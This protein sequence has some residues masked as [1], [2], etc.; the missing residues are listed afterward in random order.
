VTN[1]TLL[2]GAHGFRRRLRAVLTFLA[3]VALR[4]ACRIAVDGA[5]NVP[6]RG[7][8]I[9]VGN[10]VNPVEAPLIAGSLPRSDLWVVVSDHLRQRRA[11]RRVLDLMYDILWLNR[12]NGRAELLAR[13]PP[14]LAAGRVVA[15]MPEGRYSWNGRLGAGEDGAALLAFRT[16]AV[17]VPVVTIGLE[18]LP[19]SLKKFGRCTVAVRFGSPVHVPY[20]PNPTPTEISGAT[21]EIMQALARLLPTAKR[22]RWRTPQ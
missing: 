13:A 1:A 18:Q 3:L 12:L 6:R 22:G 16:G 21:S 2:P 17:L 8:V 5:D 7:A 4:A 9:L 11:L 14:M 20:L 15:L 10:H 19:R